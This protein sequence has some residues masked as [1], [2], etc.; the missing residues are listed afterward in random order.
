[1]HVVERYKWLDTDL[2]GTMSA[3]QTVFPHELGAL[4]QTS[5][6]L[7]RCLELVSCRVGFLGTKGA[8][9]KV[10]RIL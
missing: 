8:S 6:S 10:P 2:N 7:D 9:Y 4:D 5:G 3:I 1:M